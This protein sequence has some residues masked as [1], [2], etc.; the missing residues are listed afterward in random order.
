MTTDAR[1]VLHLFHLTCHEVPPDEDPPE[2]RPEDDP[3]HSEVAKFVCPACNHKVTV[4][5][6]VTR[7]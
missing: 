1:C 2:M 7:A 3:N 4:D 6:R 5:L